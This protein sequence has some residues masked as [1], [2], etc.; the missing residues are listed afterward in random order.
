MQIRRW[1]VGVLNYLNLKSQIYTKTYLRITHTDEHMKVIMYI[2]GKL[3]MMFLAIPHLPHLTGHCLMVTF[4]PQWLDHI[5]PRSGSGWAGWWE[6]S[7]PHLLPQP[8]QACTP[9]CLERV[10]PTGSRYFI[11]DLPRIRWTRTNL[12]SWYCPL[13]PHTDMAKT[14][15]DLRLLSAEVSCLY[16]ESSLQLLNLYDWVLVVKVWIV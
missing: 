6:R 2:R 12:T 8:P 15:P 11:S 13:P 4:S 9:S 16:V 7:S 1:S 3:K 14:D 10:N 5:R